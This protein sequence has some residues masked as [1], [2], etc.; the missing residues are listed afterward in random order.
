MKKYL[1]T[2]L[3]LPLLSCAKN[4]DNTEIP[5]AAYQTTVIADAVSMNHAKWD[6]LLQKNVSKNGNVNY[7]AFKKDS[8]KLQAYLNELAANVPT[9][10]WSKNATLAYW[11]NAYNAYTVKL[12]LDN[13]PTKSI[14]DINDP[15]GKKFFSLGNKKYSLEE[16]EHEILRKMDEPRIHFAINCASFSCPN[17]LTEAYTEAKLE[18]QLKA[19]AKSFIN[20]KTKN[21]LTENKI[22]IS[23]IFDWF[24]GDFKSKGSIIDFLNQYSTVKISS[25]AKINYKEYNWSL[26]E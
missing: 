25:K 7:K 22:E 17:L 15:W 3:L 14:K 4:K 13:Y 11:I 2:L 8:T 6:A 19:V 12:I 26:N 18:Q 21:T 1:L 16:I 10:S 20:D 24:S 5:A 9:K 23:K